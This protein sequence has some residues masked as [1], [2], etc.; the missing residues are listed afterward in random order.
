MSYQND[1]IEDASIT[2]WFTTRD[3]TTAVPTALSSGTVTVMKSGGTSTTT[4]GVTLTASVGSVTGLNRVVID[5]AATGT[6]DAFFEVGYDY[7][8]YLSAGTVGGTSVVG[9]VIGTFSMEN[10][11]YNT[12]LKALRAYGLDHLLAAAISG[13]D[14]TD[15]SALAQLVSS[16][17]TADW[18]DFNNTTDSLQATR[19]WIG[20]GTNLTETGGTG[21]Q[22]TAIPWNASWDAEV[23]SEVSDGLTA[24]NAVAT[25][26]LPSN[27]GVLAI[28]AS[29]GKVTVGT[30]DDKTGYAVSS[31]GL[32]LVT[33]WTVDITGSL[34]GSVGSVT[35]G[36]N[37]GAG[38]ITTLD[39]LD[40][41]QDTQHST[42]QSAISGLNDF[43]PTSETVDVGK[44]LGTA[45]TE[46][47]SGNLA[48]NFSFF[49][50]LDTTTTNTVDDVGGSGLDAAGV[51]AAIGLASANLDTQL[52]ALPTAAE[53]ADAVW[54]EDMTG[55]TTADTAG[56][57]L[58]HAN[59]VSTTG[60]VASGPTVNGFTSDIIGY[61]DDFFEDCVLCFTSGAIAGQPRIITSYTGST[62]AMGFDEPFTTAPSVADNF[63]IYKLHLHSGLQL[64][65]EIWSTVTAI[66]Q[67]S[68]TYGYQLKT[69][70]DS[71]LA[72]TNELQTNQGNW[73][74]A[75]GF[76]THSAADVRT[77]MDSNSTQLAAIVADTD[78]LQ[79]NQGNW[80]TADV[81]GLATAAALATVDSNVDAILVDTGTT[82]PATLTT[83]LADTNEL[84]T[85]LADG[86][87]LDLILDAILVDT[88]TTIPGTITTVDTVVDAI[89]AKTDQMNFGV[90]NQLD[91]N[92]ESINTSTVNGSG[93]SADKWRGS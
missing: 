86:G 60:A 16:S 93:T 69:I 55:H 79:T 4:E 41:A 85:D 28:T 77:E 74:T 80:T 29:T 52:D 83:I 53:N 50:D 11:V 87:R 67:T 63:V 68:G 61:D 75:T 64:A 84:Q 27:F 39:G 72:D 90:A 14:V 20:D 26:D 2:L 47:T 58:N 23:Q 92:V 31:S 81:S 51:R 30:N 15:N 38:T 17:A 35:G 18:D 24:Y 57:A 45:I 46:T 1:I 59:L 54:D 22:F 19:D 6:A 34:S 76:S 82:I 33:A 12:A 3:K 37:T 70:L 9:E 65:I 36:I 89:K 40:T 8:A 56:E 62:G 21:D 73:L 32:D 91:V 7:V 44:I 43:D 71:V 48:D 5:T 13:T 49:Y 10:R 42:T 88:S 78:E 25:T 66:G